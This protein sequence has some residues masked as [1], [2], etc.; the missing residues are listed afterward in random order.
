MTLTKPSFVLVFIVALLSG[1]LAYAQFGGGK[2]GGGG[3]G[4]G[5]GKGGPGGGGGGQPPGTGGNGGGN[6]GGNGGNKDPKAE[7]NLTN[8]NWNQSYES[9]V[10]SATNLDKY[11]LFYVYPPTET[12]DPTAFA[13]KEIAD[14]SNGNWIFTKKPLTKDDAELKGLKVTASPTIIGMDKYGNEF[15]RT[16]TVSSAAIQAL[17]KA[18]PEAVTKFKNELAAKWRD[19]SAAADEAKALKLVVEICTMGKKGYEEIEKAFEKVAE[20]GE[21]RLKMVEVLF[22]SDEPAAMKALEQLCSDFKGTPPAADAEVWL[23]RREKETKLASAI[24][25][26]LKVTVITD[27]HFKA[28]VEGAQAALDEIVAEGLAKVETAQKTAAAGE[29]DAAK[30]SL[31][32]LVNDYKGTE[33]AKKA[34]EALKEL[35][36]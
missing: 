21:K 32:K 31:G 34:S 35:A 25:R 16:T 7:D 20:Y 12:V 4:G 22:T 3:Q 5:G 33:V 29:I 23:A 18:T 9:A 2:G 19:A 27:K 36:Q 6:N 10:G 30:K 13:V 24:A 28:T 17:L 8:I 11:I 26:L 15:K 1:S 14:A